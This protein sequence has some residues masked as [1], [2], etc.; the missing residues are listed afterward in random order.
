M[1]YLDYHLSSGDNNLTKIKILYKYYLL[2]DNIFS[3]IF[4]ESQENIRLVF[5]YEKLLFT[6]YN[7]RNAIMNDNK[8]IILNMAIR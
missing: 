6:S 5:L 3:N 4:S 8:I 7:N 1:R 2:Q